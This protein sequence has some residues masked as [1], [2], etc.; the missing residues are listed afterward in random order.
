VYPLQY[1]RVEEIH[2]L[3]DPDLDDESGDREVV[4][5]GEDGDGRTMSMSGGIVLKDSFSGAAKFLIF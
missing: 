4:R 2:S 3:A 1:P 5:F